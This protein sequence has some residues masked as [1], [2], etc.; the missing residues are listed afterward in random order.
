MV[1]Q[2]RDVI[3]R[4][5]TKVGIMF[6]KESHYPFEKFEIA[7]SS[8]G[9]LVLEGVDEQYINAPSNMIQEVSGGKN[10]LISPRN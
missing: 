6:L 3:S 4:G 10:Y 5:R 2:S 9:G 1:H 8:T 7:L